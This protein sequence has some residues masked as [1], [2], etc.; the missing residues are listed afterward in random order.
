MELYIEPIIVRRPHRAGKPYSE[1]EIR[2]IEELYPHTP[3]RD[4]AYQFH[5][6]PRAIT[7]LGIKNR[8]RK[9]R[10]YM[11]TQ[12]GCFKPG[13]TPWN[14]GEKG[15]MGAN[16][17][18][19]KPGHIPVNHKPLG[20]ITTRR[21]K[22]GF[23]YKYIKVGE[24]VWELMHRH[25]YSRHHGPI[26]AGHII[27]FKDGDTL[28]CDNGNLMLLSRKDNMHRNRNYVKASGKMRDLWHREKIR[29]LYGL[30]PVSGLG[31]RIQAA[32]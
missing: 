7:Q 21:H 27:A 20:T 2:A 16:C 31:R 3:N 24:N 29:K 8:W 18:S 5:R 22:G 6:L 15:F 17:T 23:V 13:H 9:S 4:I 1:Q 12:P 30:K 14:K 25:I 10:E 11:E 26:P 28:N 19:F 32:L